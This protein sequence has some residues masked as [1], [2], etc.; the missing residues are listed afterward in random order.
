MAKRDFTQARRDAIYRAQIEGAVAQ[1]R[2]RLMKAQ[3]LLQCLAFTLEH[4]LD[5]AEALELDGGDFAD[6]AGIARDLVG[7][8]IAGLDS[9]N[10]IKPTPD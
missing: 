5:P 2:R 9:V 3:A 10:V 1:E 8:A 7:Q 4:G 6:V